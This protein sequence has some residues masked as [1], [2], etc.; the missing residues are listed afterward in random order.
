MQH[1]LRR[2]VYTGAVKVTTWWV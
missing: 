2:T 1:I